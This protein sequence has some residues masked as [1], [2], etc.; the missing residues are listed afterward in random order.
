MDPGIVPQDNVARLQL[1]EQVFLDKASKV[2]A[3]YRTFLAALNR[4][5]FEPGRKLGQI[6]RETGL[7]DHN[8]SR[9]FAEHVG[10]SPRAYRR[11]HRMEL[12]KRLLRHEGLQ[13]I[14]VA[15]IALTVGY[16][17]PDSFARE[18]WGMLLQVAV[19]KAVLGASSE[20]ERL[21]GQ[22]FG[23]FDAFRAPV[24]PGLGL[25]VWA[26][27]DGDAVALSPS[28]SLGAVVRAGPVLLQGGY[29]L[30]KGGAQF[31]FAV[32]FRRP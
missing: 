30:I 18:R 8:I 16:E 31:G 5:L 12:A 1:W 3:L 21:V 9:R 7:R 10:M 17:R 13:T 27:E 29:D 28:V 2:P 14:P 25:G 23:F 26:E 11:R 4:H 22:F 24:M 15:Q 6:E 20:P 19:N 32:T